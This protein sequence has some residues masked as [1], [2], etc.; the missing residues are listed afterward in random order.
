MTN[1]SRLQALLLVVLLCAASPP[2][3]RMAVLQRGVNITN[4]FRF[5][6]SR[7][8]AAL[9]G[10]IGDGALAHLRRVGFTFVRLPVQ[11]E[12]LA[13]AS[14]R[15]ALRAAIARIERQGLGVIGV[16][17]PLAWRLE[18]SEADRAA[19]S[20]SWR[21][22]APLLGRFDPALTFPELLNEPVFANAS[23]GWRAL[24]HKTL[25]QVRQALPLNTIV[26][27]GNDWGSIDGLLAVVPEA[28]P[29]VVYSLHFYDPVELTSLAAWRAD[30]DRTLLAR[31]PFPVR[32]VA[33][34]EAI[35]SDSVTGGVVRFY[36][37]ERWDE[38]R[39]AT[40]IDAAA[41]WARHN[42]VAVLVG[43]FGATMGLNAPAR[44]AWLAAVR[45]ACERAG[46]GWALWGYDDIMGFAMPRPPRGRVDLDPGTLRAL[47]PGA[48]SAK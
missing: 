25:A 7:D 24:Q 33:A 4:W 30:V 20:E 28:D 27:T 45:Q 34:C 1:G 36:C 18:S 32:D 44:Q 35:G 46:I 38:A 48:I 3:E 11:P 26:L 19:L 42:N 17:H 9:R 23:D 10:Y 12:L 14:V 13:D 29:D 6:A 40:R 16:L 21:V 39:I 22:L 41:A 47:F 5:P 37:R 15:D 43:E 8:P 31:L 2:P